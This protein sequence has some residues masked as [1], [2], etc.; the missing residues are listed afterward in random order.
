MVICLDIAAPAARQVTPRKREFTCPLV[1]VVAVLRERHWTALVLWT[2]QGSPSAGRATTLTTLSDAASAARQ[3][4]QETTDKEG[5]GCN[6]GMHPRPTDFGQPS[7]C[8]ICPGQSRTPVAPWA[9]RTPGRECALWVHEEL[10]SLLAADP[11]LQG[12][13]FLQTGRCVELGDPRVHEDVPQTPSGLRER[14]FQADLGRGFR[15]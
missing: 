12:E 9:E 14:G 2:G 11:R 8:R 5:S 7:P 15:W 1:S 10:D 3:T 6:L 13:G 4:L